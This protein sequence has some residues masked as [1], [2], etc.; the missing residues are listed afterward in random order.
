MKILIKLSLILAGFVTSCSSATLSGLERRVIDSSGPRPEWALG[1]K[2]VLEEGEILSFRSQST[3]RGDERIGSCFDLSRLQVQE[4]ILTEIQSTLRGVL[5]QAQTS[6]SEAVELLLTKSL[7][8]EFSGRIRGVRTTDEYFERYRI[9]DSERIE[10]YTLNQ[11]RKSEFDQIRQALVS[12]MVAADPAVKAALS[13]GQSTFF[14][15][16]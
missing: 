4:R 12:Q 16:K 2:A 8:S 7:S 15:T 6:P 9:G 5:N 3:V 10:C 13:E 11:I 1:S 14:K